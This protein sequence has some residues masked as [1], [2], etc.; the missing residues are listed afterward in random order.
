MQENFLINKSRFVAYCVSDYPALPKG[1]LGLNL[2]VQIRLSD[3][4]CGFEKWNVL[5][6]EG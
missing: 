6:I 1:N 5:P 2:P 3:L 4:A